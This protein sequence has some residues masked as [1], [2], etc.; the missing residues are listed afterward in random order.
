MNP[1]I[2]QVGGDKAGFSLKRV[3]LA[4][5]MVAKA[6]ERE[7]VLLRFNDN[8]TM[9]YPA[10]AQLSADLRDLIAGA[11][12]NVGSLTVRYLGDLKPTV[13]PIGTNFFHLGKTTEDGAEFGKLIQKAL[14][15]SEGQELTFVNLASVRDVK[16]HVGNYR[17]AMITDDLSFLTT[18]CE[19]CELWANSSSTIT[20][21]DR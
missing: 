8:N 19:T 12:K 11:M 1:V 4:I 7:A 13:Y 10:I 3:M 9:D 16:I 5:D 17:A 21:E 18:F 6:A 20:I 15:E 14:L 2:T